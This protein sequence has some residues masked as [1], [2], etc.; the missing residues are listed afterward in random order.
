MGES[1]GGSVSVVVRRAVMG[2]LEALWEIERECFS[3][4]EAFLRA[5][6]AY[7]LEASEGVS[8]VAE[9]DGEV[10]GFVAGLI[11]RRGD[12]GR[13]GH[14]YTLD[15]RAGHRRKGVASRLLDGL[16]RAFAERGIAAC[17]LEVRVDNVAALR[18][19]SGRG[20][21]VVERLRDYYGRGVHGLRL[22]R[23]LPSL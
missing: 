10:V 9:V 21:A 11:E 13:V 15:V 22:K 14:V 23:D 17:I 2:D 19:Y 1:A 18:L 5:E 7:L 4:A 12:G 8:L 3:A 20:Y 16:E 6:I